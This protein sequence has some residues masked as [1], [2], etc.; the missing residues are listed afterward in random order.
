M[1]PEAGKPMAGASSSRAAASSAAGRKFSSAID[2][3]HERLELR[4]EAVQLHVAGRDAPL[5]H[6]LAGVV[7]LPEGPVL[8]AERLR[9]GLQQQV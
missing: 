4:A 8:R 9:V 7:N 3:V 1:K 5:Q 6:H 2:L